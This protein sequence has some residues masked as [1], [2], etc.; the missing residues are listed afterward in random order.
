VFRPVIVT[1]L[2]LVAGAT[3]ALAQQAASVPMPESYRG[4][5]LKALELQRSMLLAM[6]DSMPESLYRDKVTPPQRDFAQQIHHAASSV[7]AIAAVYLSKPGAAPLARTELGTALAS[8]PDTATTF[9]SRAG[10]KS[11]INAAY[12]YAAGLLKN[13]SADDRALVVKFFGAMD[14]PKW[15]V[16]DELHE[17]TMW[18]AGQVV[19]NFRKQGM[20]P[21]GFGFF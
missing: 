2:A 7:A 3:G 18:T 15:Q 21:P 6:A 14:I 9:N 20:A 12:D 10:L 1:A 17:H 5:Q 13:Q 4:T 19:A 16:W 8:L 11:Y